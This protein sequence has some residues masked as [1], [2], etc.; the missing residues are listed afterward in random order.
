[1]NFGTDESIGNVLKRA[2]QSCDPKKIYFLLV[3]IYEKSGKKEHAQQTYQTMTKKFSQSSK[4]WTSMGLFHIKNGDISRSRDLLQ[5][6][7][8]TLNLL[9]TDVKVITKFAQMEFKHG[10]VE[11]GRTIFEG[12][13]SNYPKRVDLWSIYI[14]MECKVGDPDIVR[15]TSFSKDNDDEIFIE[16]D[17]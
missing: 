4:V 6:S 1:N 10:E 9:W 2:L 13:M 8:Q 11:R 17:E 7:L 15:Q 14:D 16:K 5:R 3:G 12:M